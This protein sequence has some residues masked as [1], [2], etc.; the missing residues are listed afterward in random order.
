VAYRSLV[1]R[2]ALRVVLITTVFVV[3]FATHASAQQD[4][5]AQPKSEGNFLTRFI[6]NFFNDSQDIPNTP[7]S[8]NSGPPSDLRKFPAP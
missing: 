2:L 7:W 3:V 4:Q 8:Y 6:G 5:P 1:A